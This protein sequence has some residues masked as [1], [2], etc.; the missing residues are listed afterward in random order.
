MERPMMKDMELGAAPHEADPISNM[1]M[2]VSK[3]Y[4][5]LGRKMRSE[6]EA[7]PFR[8][9]ELVYSSKDKLG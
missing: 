8:A 1:K 4:K 3:T 9:V 7:N 5:M 2:Q 6:R